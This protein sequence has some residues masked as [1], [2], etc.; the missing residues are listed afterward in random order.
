[1]LFSDEMLR[2]KLETLSNEFYIADSM[3]AIQ[4]LECEFKI[5]MRSKI[6]E[7]LAGKFMYNQF[8]VKL[9]NGKFSPQVIGHL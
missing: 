3:W 4:I 7:Q 5:L 1:M 6:E 2:L 8:P 9:P